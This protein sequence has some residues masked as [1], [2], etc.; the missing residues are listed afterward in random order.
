MSKQLFKL[1]TDFKTACDELLEVGDSFYSE[2]GR[3]TT[4]AIIDKDLPRQ[5][6]L[7]RSHSLEEFKE[8]WKREDTFNSYVQGN[9]TG[10][11]IGKMFNQNKILEY[12]STDYMSG[13]KYLD[14]AFIDKQGNDCAFCL[15]YNT[16]CPEFF[17]L[18][19][20]KN[21]RAAP[22]V[23]H[24]LQR[25]EVPTSEELKAI[26]NNAYI[27]TDKEFLY[28]DCT[29]N[30][31][32]AL[33]FKDEKSLLSLKKDLPFT[34]T[35]PATKEELE[36]IK[37]YTGH[38]SQVREITLYQGTDDKIFPGLEVLAG[39]SWVKG[40]LVDE[41]KLQ[42]EVLNYPDLPEEVGYLICD[43]IDDDGKVN[44]ER[45]I[46][47]HDSDKQYDNTRL[48]CNDTNAHRLF[49]IEQQA[50]KDLEV[51]KIFCEAALERLQPGDNKTLYERISTT[52][53]TI[54][55]VLEANKQKLQ[56]G[57]EGFVQQRD[58]IQNT[59]LEY[60][61]EGSVN[62]PYKNAI[63]KMQ[64]E[65][66]ETNQSLM[67]RRG[68]ELMTSTAFSVLAVATTAMR[69]T[70]VAVTPVGWAFAATMGTIAAALTVA[71]LITWGLTAY[72]ERLFA[73]QKDN[74]DKTLK[75]EIAGL[76]QK[77]GKK[78]ALDLFLDNPDA[79]ANTQKF[80]ELKNKL[81]EMTNKGQDHNLDEKNHSRPS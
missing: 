14:F 80:Q 34:E 51:Y 21:T 28:F 74:L 65:L 12:V 72:G 58:T 5:A 11:S 30:E 8:R 10:T 33:N 15:T 81:Q 68:P 13:L 22:G 7:S 46:P 23:C 60:L 17:T 4:Q 69:A 41:T 42:Q 2:E 64:K 29:K 53:D 55:S 9:G 49:G 32:K 27:L 57:E 18:L 78:D 61:K 36:L 44:I 54:N 16:E 25:E 79:K 75:K 19:M 47:Y 76:E 37:S 1:E 39:K 20:M 40:N 59:I 73:K 71:S 38:Y 63:S 24:L 77:G 26:G 56:A 48:Q 6:Y 62:E 31:L 66:G 50:Q 35:H 45:A 70:G 52:L 43:I 3:D 67:Q